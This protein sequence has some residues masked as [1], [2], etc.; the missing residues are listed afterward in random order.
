MGRLRMFIPL[1][2]CVALGGM[3]YSMLTREGYNPQILP[4]ALI[5]KSVPAFSIQALETPERTMTEADLKGRVILLNVW[6]TWCPTCRI[7][8]PHLMDISRQFGIPIIGLN[9]KDE[10]AK[11]M[12]WLRQLG[13]PYEVNIADREGGLGL[14]LGVYGAPETYVIDRQGVIRYKHV[15]EVDM[16]IWLQD[17]KPVVDRLRAEEQ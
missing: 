4:S 11:A 8:H 10:D 14:D 9:Y 17:L 15:G 3:F 12:Q 5:G 6:A 13:N 1:L 7:E 16:N 2:L